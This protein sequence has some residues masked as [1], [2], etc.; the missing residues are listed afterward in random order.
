[1]EALELEPFEEWT[2]ILITVVTKAR[3][4][5]SKKHACRRLECV[6]HD[7][8]D[9]V[10]DALIHHFTTAPLTS[11]LSPKRQANC[12]ISLYKHSGKSAGGLLLG[13]KLRYR[14]CMFPSAPSLD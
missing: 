13:R 6:G 7:Y 12:L 4:D 10:S 11:G 5:V 3:D 1:M 9:L 14:V 8:S 2:L